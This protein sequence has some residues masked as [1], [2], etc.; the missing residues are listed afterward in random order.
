MKIELR[1][2]KRHGESEYLLNSQNKWICKKCRS[3]STIYHRRKTKLKA[4]NYLG[5]C[6]QLC[7]YS[8]CID[9]LEFH[10]KDEN[11]KDIN[12]TKFKNRS[13]EKLQCELD[14]CML[15]CANCHRELHEIIPT[16]NTY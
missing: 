3:E 12:Y 6:C 16:Y 15:V 14:K 1:K 13:W 4:I 10:H 11:D 9:A 2:C 7:G 8:K 5:G